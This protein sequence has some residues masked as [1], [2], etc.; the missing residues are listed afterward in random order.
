MDTP[1]LEIKLFGRVIGRFLANELYVPIPWFRRPFCHAKEDRIPYEEVKRISLM[2]NNSEFSIY[3]AVK[4]KTLVASR[5]SGI[6]IPLG[7]GLSD[8]LARFQQSVALV[9]AK[10]PDAEVHLPPIFQ[11]FSK[12]K[13]CS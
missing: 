5:R 4:D 11:G 13:V 3:V 12:K 2:R 9:K 8:A 6:S 7:L 10:N 1:N